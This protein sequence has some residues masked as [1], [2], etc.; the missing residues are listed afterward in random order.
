MV[1]IDAQG[2]GRLDALLLLGSGH[3]PFRTHVPDG[4]RGIAP[5]PNLGI[6]E[7]GHSA[8]V[9][10][11]LAATLMYTR[12]HVLIFCDNLG[13]DAPLFFGLVRL[14]FSNRS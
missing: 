14:L 3:T 5:N 10:G 11:V 12:R 7:F 2:L 8:A 9:R 4:M 13:S 1:Y 6:F